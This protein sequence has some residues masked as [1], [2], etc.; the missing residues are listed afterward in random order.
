M[1]RHA[2]QRV[3]QA[4]FVKQ[5]IQNFTPTG[6]PDLIFANAALQFVDEHRALFP[7]LM[8]FLPAGGCL[9][10]QMP[11]TIQEASHALM[12]MIAA[13]GHWV[14]RL[15]PVAKSRPV[16]ASPGEYY[17]WLQ[18]FASRITLWRTTYMHALDGAGGVADWFAG[19][20]LRPFLEPLTAAERTT[21][22]DR[23]RQEIAREYAP[24]N[25]GRI[26]LPY[27]R[28]FIVAAR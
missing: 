22:L 26:L 27:P 12:R 3:P 25:D 16:I 5:D 19:S 14:D 24:R 9:A 2:R 6:N 13:D 17:D 4:Q 20:G 11:D 21:F 28:L 1:L 15:M 10:V 8:S 18:P 23:Y 7:R